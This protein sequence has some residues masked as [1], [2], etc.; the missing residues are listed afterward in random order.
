MPASL[1]AID[2]IAPAF[3][4]TKRQLFQP[5]RFAVWARMALIALAT[6][7][8]YSS[9]GWGGFHYTMPSSRRNPSYIFQSAVQ[10]HW[11]YLKRYL[12]W[13]IL[14]TVLLFGLAFLWAYIA[15]VF[16]FILFDSVLTDRCAIKEQWR[17]WSPQGFRFF[18]WKIC[19][20]LGVLL[21]LGMLAGA[22]ILL[23]VTTG[24]YLNL[25]HHIALLI[26][27]G[28]LAFLLLV[29][30]MIVAAL[31]G[32]FARDFVVPVMALENVGVID[33][34]RRVIALLGAETRAYV[35]YVLMKIVLVVGSTIIFGILTLIA[36][37]LLFI[38]ISIA[39]VA[40]YFFAKSEGLL[41]GFPAITVGIAL[42][43]AV[44]ALIC[45]LT[46][47]ISAP[48]MVFFQAYV[49]DFFGSRYPELGARLAAPPAP[50]APP[51]FPDGGM[52]PAG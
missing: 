9:S 32:L 33:G 2:A 22:V 41:W 40:A 14:G 50:P 37:I 19:L 47:L 1:S 15:S 25:G 52:I 12:P 45:Y 38:P 8:F 49:I 3:N 43:G 6:G 27:G 35:G 42:G 18:L 51:Y 17:E 23:L 11:E 4:R 46:A 36:V 5:F 44:L 31:I 20:G 34:W 30:L 24:A 48:A 28:V 29:G 13:I 26:L 10:P 21:A 16:R 39:G 7:E